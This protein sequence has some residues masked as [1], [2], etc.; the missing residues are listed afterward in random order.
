LTRI[1]GALQ[2]ADLLSTRET[3]GLE[4]AI[5]RKIVDNHDSLRWTETTP[6]PATSSMW[7]C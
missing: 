3:G 1:F 2:R 6:D 4:L 7:S 5:C